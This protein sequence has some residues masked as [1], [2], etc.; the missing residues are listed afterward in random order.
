[1]LNALRDCWT[2]EDY[3]EVLGFVEKQLWLF[4]QDSAALHRPQQIICSLAQLN[5]RDLRL[6]QHIYFLLSQSVQ[7][8]ILESTPRI[9]RR[10]AQSTDR[11]AGVCQGG[12][13]GNVDWGLTLKRQLGTGMSTPTVFVTRAAVKTY[14]LPE[15]QALKFLLTVANRLCLEVLGSI[16][17]EG[18]TLSYQPDEKW[19]EKIRSLYYLTNT[20]LKT[21]Y[22]R[23]I[24]LPVRITDVMLQ[25]VRCARNA[26]FKSVYES[27]RLYRSL[28]VQEEN[29]T[30]RDCFAQGVLKPLSNDT[31]FEIY[32]LLTTMESLKQKGWNQEHLRLIGY[33]KGAIAEYRCDDA[34]LHLYYQT[35]P[36]VFAENSLYTNMMQRY[37]IDASLRRPDM[38]FEF[39]TDKRNFSLLEVKRTSDRNYIAESIY[40]VLGYL[41]DFESCFIQEQLP[42]AMLVVW[43]GIDRSEES[44]DVLVVLNRHNYRKFLEDSVIMTRGAR[45]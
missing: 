8:T 36:P 40:K 4:V 10:L 14:D 9:L 11:V 44:N 1:M 5:Y 12:V 25:R 28:F 15:M 38:L 18:E 31:L 29:E 3:D 43:E 26:N 37:S 32:I 21:A 35:L 6:L 30:L 13:R 7:K 16:P 23:D 22:M 39:E 2:A 17:E 34:R 42:H 27:L 45:N 19:K 24:G 41:K 33:G 20:F